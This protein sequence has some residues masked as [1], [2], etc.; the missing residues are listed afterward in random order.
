M[1]WPCATDLTLSRHPRQACGVSS[2][3][4]DDPRTERF[5]NT[6]YKGVREALATTFL[7]V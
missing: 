7:K 1:T 5:P 6:D 3:K 2:I 4:W